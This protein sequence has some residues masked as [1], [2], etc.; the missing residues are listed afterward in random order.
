MD[1]TSFTK[2]SFCGVEIDNITENDT[3]QYI[4]NQ[5]HVLCSGVQYKTRYAKVYNEQ[6]SRNL[7][8]P[9][10][11]CLKSSGTP[12]FM[13]L[14]QIGDTNYCFLIDKKIKEGY[15]YPKIFIL[16]FQLDQEFYKGSLYECELL[17]DR[18]NDWSILIGDTYYHKGENQ[19]NVIVIDRMNHIHKGFESG[20]H[21]TPFL[22]TCPITIKKYFDYKDVSEIMSELV[23]KLS[24]DIRG[25][26]FVPLRCSYSKILYLFP[27]NNKHSTHM[28]KQTKV[29]EAKVAE[30]KVA[31]TKVAETNHSSHTIVNNKSHKKVFRIMKTLKP[32][33]YELYGMKNTDLNKV[34]VA[35]V[36]T[37]SDSR[38][39]CSVFSDVNALTEVRVECEYISSFKKWRPVCQTK[40][41]ISQI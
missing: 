4:L 9:H 6:Y 36:Q 37:I 31:E 15:N 38:M 27:R 10:V 3:K 24:Y 32:D 17:R 18:N 28:S 2:T 23:P 1:P 22:K 26:Y 40:S 5:L 21:D 41:H 13:F 14:S 12:Y 19:K 8:N 11:V 16:P 25:L 35:L 20:L 33:V 29:A 7:K 39:L 30:A 34:G